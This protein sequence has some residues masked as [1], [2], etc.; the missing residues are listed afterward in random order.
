MK[1][2]RY[3]NHDIEVVIDKLVVNDKDDKR[4]R[5]SLQTA[6]KQGDGLIMLYDVESG[7]VR[8]YSKRLMCPVTGLAYK[9]P[10]PH[11]FSFNSPQGACSRCKGE[12]A[13]Q[14]EDHL[15]HRRDH[16]GGSS[17]GHRRLL[18]AGLAGA[19]T[20]GFSPLQ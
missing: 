3:K 13:Q 4:L 16:R 8:H 12:K 1:V 2:D 10:A 9:E 19:G 17:S 14:R 18:P 20:D 7:E 6:M 11:N 15:D 5:Q